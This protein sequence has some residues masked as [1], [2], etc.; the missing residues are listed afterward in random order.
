MRI[1]P[2]AE[3]VGA[4]TPEIRWCRLVSINVGNL[5]YTGSNG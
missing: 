4:A 3:V 5:F 1:F 2:V